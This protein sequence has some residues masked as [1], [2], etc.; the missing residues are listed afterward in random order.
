M[1]KKVRE[2]PLKKFSPKKRTKKRH[3]YVIRSLKDMVPHSWINQC[4]DTFGV[5]ENVEILLPNSMEKWIMS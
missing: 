5:A 4:L 3:E 1:Q 2:Y